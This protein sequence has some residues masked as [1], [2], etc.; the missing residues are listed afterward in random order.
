MGYLLRFC[1]KKGACISKT[2]V[3]GPI[4]TL[5]K[6]RDATKKKYEIQIC[7][8]KKKSHF[9]PAFFYFS[10]VLRKCVNKHKN[11]V[12]KKK[13]NGYIFQNVVAQIFSLIENWRNIGKFIQFYHFLKFFPNFIPQKPTI[14]AQ[15][16]ELPM[17]F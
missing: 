12:D 3:F 15:L 11:E 7:L 1:V 9:K 17:N 13:I 16:K 4:Y 2:C 6:I 8:L 10:K 5:A 14:N